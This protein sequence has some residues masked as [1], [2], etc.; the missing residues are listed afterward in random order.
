MQAKEPD[1]KTIIWV[2]SFVRRK[3]GKCLF[4][5][6]AGRSSWGAGQWQ[7][8][9]GKLEWGETP[10]ETLKR[11]INEETNSGIKIMKLIYPHTAQIAAKGI[12]YHVIELIYDCVYSGKKITLSKEHDD[13]AWLDAKESLKLN[14]TPELR[15]LITKIM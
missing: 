5:K 4:L 9:G 13:Y 7:L 15:E 8:P 10:E 2:G 11:E 3:D 14:L 1:K 6:R 12:R